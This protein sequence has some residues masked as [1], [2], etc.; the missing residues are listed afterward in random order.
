MLKE[1]L[2]TRMLLLKRATIMEGI[3]GKNP[4]AKTVN[5]MNRGQAKGRQRLLKNAPLGQ[6]NLRGRLMWAG[7]IFFIPVE[8]R[9]EQRANPRPQ[10]KGRPLGEGHNEDLRD[11]KLR[12][13]Q[14]QIH[15]QMLNGI[16]L[17]GARRSLDDGMII[18]ADLLQE[19]RLF[20][21]M[22]RRG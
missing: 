17:P 6:A 3:L 20:D 21:A 8:D 22:N 10:L 5:G 1:A 7:A 15:H 12:I 19:R 2:K 14:Q 9:L 16:G 18:V 11:A 13:L 4:V